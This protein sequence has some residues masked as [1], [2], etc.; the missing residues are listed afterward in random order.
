MATVTRENMGT[1]H[2]KVL[3][4]LVKED[5]MPSFEKTLKQYAKTANVPGFRKGMVPAG[6]I[7]KMYG[8]S[9]FGDEVVRTAG[10]A[11]EDYLKGEQ[12]AIFAQPMILPSEQPLRLDMNNA[13]DMDF[14]FEIGLKPEFEVTPLKA[15]NKLTRYKI[16]VGDK[17]VNDEVERITRKYGKVEDQETIA[18]AND[19]IYSTY[20]ACDAEGNVNADAKVMEDTVTLEKV[21]AKLKEMLKGKKAQD[22]L[23]FRPMDVCTTEE[24]EGFLK[25]PLKQSAEA[26]TEHFKLTITKI[27]LLIPRELDA[28][29]YAQ[30]FPNALITDEKGFKEAIKTELGREY[31]R[32]SRDRM[33]NEIYE[34]LVHNTHFSLPVPFLKRWMK[35]GGEKPKSSEEVE[36]EYGSFE[37][38]LRWTLISDKLLQ[39]YGISVNRE[40]VNAD[41]KT[42]VLAY[43][44][45]DSD[46]EAPW[47]DGY[48]AKV[49]KDEKTIDETYRR[50]LFEKLFT[51]LETKFDVEER[52]VEEEEFYKLPDAHAAH[53][54]HH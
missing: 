52:Q 9:V 1:L 51:Q 18:N 34:M 46:E 41:I 30:V 35:D 21:P 26:A 16:S 7:R 49:A 25:D 15:K 28:E 48:M 3:V 27:G 8:Q 6:M 39:E 2:E 11:L 50:L 40:E 12:V 31:E 24:L 4:K 53:H 19:I 29:L 10:K 38:Q 43:F 45:M 14:A 44:G 36:H 13:A 17:M 42:R 32:V 23:V 5:Y 33:H 54:H 37:H 20:Q 47:I 22:T